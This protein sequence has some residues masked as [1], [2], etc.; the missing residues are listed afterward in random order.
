MAQDPLPLLL[1]GPILRRVE[2]R[3]VSVFV[4]T[5]VDVAVDLTVYEGV[6]DAASPP[7]ALVS[8]HAQT[9]RFGA[10]FHATVVTASITD[11]NVL[12][13]G[14]R[15]SY[16][17][18]I[19]PGG[20]A[21]ES[22][23]D[24]E[25]LEDKTTDGYKPSDPLL[26]DETH[27]PEQADVEICSIGYAEGQLPSFLTCPE[28][29]TDLVLAHCSCRKP[30]GAGDPAMQYLD[31][32]I[33]DLHGADAGRPHMLFLTG[34]QI[35]ADDVAAALA[36]G[37]NSLG[38]RLIS[39]D[40]AAT[41]VEQV[42]S[43]TMGGPAGGPLNVNTA[44]L[45]PGFRQKPMGL[46]GF[47]SESAACHLIGFGEWLAMYCIAWNPE[48]WPVLAVADISDPSVPDDLKGALQ[49]DARYSPDAAPKVLG[50]PTPDAP[51]SVIA[52]LYDDNTEAKKALHDAFRGFLDDK[53]TLDAFRREVPKVRRLL[54]NVPTYM[55][56]DDH[57][58]SDD[59]FMTGGIRTNTTK[60]AFGKAVVR[61]ALAAY[62][63]CQ[64]W[65][66]EPAAWANDTDHQN[67]LTGISEMFGAGWSGGLPQTDGCNKVDTALGLAPDAKP[68]FDFS[69]SIDGPV[70]RVRVLDTRTRRLY[71]TPYS[72][73]GL[74]TDDALDHQLP[75]ETLPD[76][77]VLIV[78]SPAPV[79]GPAAMNEL[80]GIFAADEHD[81]AMFARSETTRSEQQDITGIPQGQPLGREFYDAEH[82]SADPACFERL[83]ERLSFFPRV[84]V[85][86]GDVHYGAAYAMD[87][88]G[89]GRNSRIIHF[90]SSA[91]RNAWTHTVRNLMLLN[92]M[93]VGLQQIG[94]PMKRLGWSAT[95][96]VVVSGDIS[97]EPP[98]PRVR[99]LTAPVLLSDELFRARY[100][101]ARP[102]EWIWQC[103]AIVDERAPADRPEAARMEDLDSDIPSGHA[104]VQ[105]YGDVVAAHV[106]GLDKVAIARGLQF[107]N[108]V[109]VVRFADG[110]G[111]LHVSQSLYSLRARPD[112]HEGA[113]A[114]IVHDAP[115]EPVAVAVPTAVGPGD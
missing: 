20:G 44:V 114:Y 61:N 85:F 71:P 70:H 86:G 55:I 32:V 10:N 15:Y 98:L 37:L 16:D 34:D 46:S 67:L 50:R 80:G 65:G 1:I 24:L 87:W 21:A 97:H 5:S 47:T 113:D 93:S 66:N 26:H 69:Y 92:G 54:A 111:G 25:L 7:A 105:H 109:S 42:P 82:W 11:T 88:S 83:L 79:F 27:H 78:V 104:A 4:A 108:N 76:G 62:T 2:P 53:R 3:H 19:A 115:L 75:K 28:S 100:A 41:G 43:P 49:D 33:D 39:G 9:T 89:S 99:L 31:G 60:R 101:L 94:M 64:G 91:A 6:V 56:G 40:G 102:P 52:P 58:V 90:T 48:L 96:P 112:P 84:V 81:V 73:P 22:L 51:N 29:L 45:P 63:V 36:P 30:H 17:V 18:R 103:R 107:L 77:H 72:S 59:F 74:L 57:E 35:Y 68:K 23:K 38:I 95:L 13:P 8:G 12:Q 110:D 14:H 106:D